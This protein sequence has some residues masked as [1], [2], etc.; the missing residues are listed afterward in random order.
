[1]WDFEWK[2]FICIDCLVT[3]GLTY[4]FIAYLPQ[5]PEAVSN[6]LPGSGQAGE[7]AVAALLSA[8]LAK[9]VAHQLTD[10]MNVP[11]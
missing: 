5:I 11:K 8:M 3:A 9:P 4:L 1:M 6:L 2:K 10:L 7:A